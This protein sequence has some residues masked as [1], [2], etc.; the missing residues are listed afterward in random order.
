MF[1]PK[2]I[3]ELIANFPKGLN[4][5]DNNEFRKAHVCRHYFELSLTIINEYQGRQRLIDVDRIPSMK[6]I[7]QEIIWNIH[8]D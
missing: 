7:T 2:L 3:K 6:I 5:A 1:Y 4:E 8:D